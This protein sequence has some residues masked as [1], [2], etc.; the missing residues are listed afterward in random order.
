MEQERLLGVQRE[1]GV[2][3]DLDLVVDRD[4]DRRVVVRLVRLVRL[5][6]G[7]DVVVLLRVEGG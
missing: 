1:G 5:V 2:E 4:R 6:L 7:V 3:V